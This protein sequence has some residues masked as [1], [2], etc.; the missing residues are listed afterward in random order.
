MK[1]KKL[2]IC[3]VLTLITC[4]ALI[5]T[6]GAAYEPMSSGGGQVAPQAE[7]TVWYTRSNP[8]TGKVEKRLWSITRR[9]WLTEW[10]PIN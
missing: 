3:F 6:A 9:I 1:F 5:G 7:E 8:Q 4:S 2:V 10:I